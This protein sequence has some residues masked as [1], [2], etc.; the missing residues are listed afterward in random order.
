MGSMSFHRWVQ[1]FRWLYTVELEIFLTQ[2]L[3]YLAR[4]ENYRK[5]SW[6]SAAVGAG[7]H[8]IH[9]SALW[10]FLLRKCTRC[11]QM[12]WQLKRGCCF[13]NVFWWGTAGGKWASHSS[14]NKSLH[15]YQFPSPSLSLSRAHSLF[16]SAFCFHWVEW[17][18]QLSS[19]CIVTRCQRR[20]D[21]E[22]TQ[23]LLHSFLYLQSW[24]QV[25]VHVLGDVP[26]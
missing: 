21:L 4:C 10:D 23:I 20:V 12:Q 13:S 19:V 17:V 9:V 22:L 7:F 6:L 15:F 14:A 1:L 18:T 2:P 11:K 16:P 3:V 24:M 8:Q 5:S 25:Q 26:W